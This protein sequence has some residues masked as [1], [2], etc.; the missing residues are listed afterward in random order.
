MYWDVPRGAGGTPFAARAADTSLA[1][2]S[3]RACLGL[4]FIPETLDSRHQPIK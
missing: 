3:L 4:G 1:S 2:A